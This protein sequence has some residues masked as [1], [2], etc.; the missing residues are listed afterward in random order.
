MHKVGIKNMVCPRCVMA[1]QEVLKSMMVD[2]ERVEL[3]QVMFEQRP[4]GSFLKDFEEKLG[5]LGFSLARSRETVWVETTKLTLI[6][7]LEGG[8]IKGESPLS[9]LLSSKTGLPYS[10]LSHLF[11]SLEGMS[12]EQYFIGLK[13]EK[14]KEWLSYESMN[15]SEIAWSLDYSSVQHFSA[16]FKKVTGLTPSQFKKLNQ[17]P[18]IFLDQVGKSQH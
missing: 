12:I 3:G 11:S 18:R 6:Q 15:I 17:K 14:A 16:Q 7:L 13:I 4:D 10:R 1:V 5:P 9:D 8:N 2:F